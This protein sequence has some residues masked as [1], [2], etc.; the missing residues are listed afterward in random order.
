[1]YLV[2]CPDNIF[3]KA[4][5]AANNNKL[6]EEDFKSIFDK[7]YNSEI[8]FLAGGITNCPNW[9]SIVIEALK[10]KRCVL[11]N[12]RR[13]NWNINDSTLEKKQIEWE[14]FHLNG[15]TQIIF[16]FPKE[17]L[18]PIT[19]FELGKH[20]KEEVKLYIGCHPEYARKND[21]RIQTQLERPNQIIHESLD[22]LLKEVL[23]ELED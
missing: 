2:Q 23:S 5:E 14:H 21:V 10:N 3:I 22:D 19:L 13:D 8:I 16:W 1:M 17:T 15:S 18:C 20:L 7:D 6:V 9:Q 12:P 4:L 11:I